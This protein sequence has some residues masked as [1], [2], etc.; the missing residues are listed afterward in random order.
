MLDNI[1]VEDILFLDI[2][3]V[4][5]V[6]SYDLLDPFMQALWEKKSKQ[7]RTADQSGKEVYERAGIYSEFG[8][9]ICIS[10]GL[11]KEKNPLSLRLKSF[12]GDD[13][14]LLLS[15]FSSMLTRMCRTNKEAILCAHN[16]K[17]FDYPYIARRMIINGL[18]IPE[19]L[20]NSGKK[21]WEVKL[22]DTMDLWKF[23]DYKNYT[24]LELLTTVLGISTPKD[25]IDGSMVAGV[26][27]TE[28]DIER[29]VRYCEKDVLAIVQVML[30]FMHLPVIDK[31]RIESVTFT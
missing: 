5:V 16:G 27:Y 1:K 30:R 11:I 8:R 19:I 3:T 26:Y 2:E 21:P 6:E 7:F 29:I 28:R 9:I 24:S 12:Y 4:P 23:G 13:E 25:D 31:E 14:E 15:E 20:D 10:V 18:V 22:L 17:E